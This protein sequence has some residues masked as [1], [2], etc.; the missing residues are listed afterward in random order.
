MRKCLA[1]GFTVAIVVLN[2]NPARATTAVEAKLVLIGSKLVRLDAAIAAGA[3]PT[4]VTT[5]E[6]IKSDLGKLK[7]LPDL[8][9][10]DRVV[11][12]ALGTKLD[13]LGTKLDA[14]PG[15][16]AKEVMNQLSAKYGAGWEA[17]A[18]KGSNTCSTYVDALKDASSDAQVLKALAD[19]IGECA[20]QGAVAVDLAKVVCLNGGVVKTNTMTIVCDAPPAKAEPDWATAKPPPVVSSRSSAGWILSTLGGAAALGTAGWYAGN[21]SAPVKVTDGGWDG[22]MGPPVAIIGSLV[23]G[24]VGAGV[25]ALATGESK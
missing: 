1:V 16:T 15:L 19:A 3:C 13:A 6:V 10:D 2:P 8:R 18:R 24:L 21:K 20:K 12:D 22:G 9:K 7:A 17:A 4:C 5:L 23:G 11:L 25:Y 14:T